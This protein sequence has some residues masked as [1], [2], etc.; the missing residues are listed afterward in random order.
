M[1]II[2]ITSNLGNLLLIFF[3]FTL[4]LLP[5]REILSTNNRLI[6]TL[7]FIILLPLF[8]IG[9]EELKT[10]LQRLRKEKER[11][12]KV[13]LFDFL[14]VFLATLATF[15]LSVNLGFGPVVAAGLTGILAALFVRRYEAAAYCGA[16]VGMSCP[17]GLFLSFGHLILAAAIAGIIFVIT[18]QAFNGIGGKLGTIALA[19]CAIATF[20]IGREFPPGLPPAGETLG[21]L[22][23]YSVL[24]GLITY[25]LN[26]RL[27]HSAVL[28]SAVVGLA[29]GL[30]LPV[31]YPE[32]GQVLG[33]MV[34]CASFA[35]MSNFERIPCEFYM[36]ITGIFCA[37]IFIYTAPY[38]GGAGGKLGA[39]AFGSV[40]AI[41]G[42]RRSFVVGIKR[43]RN[44][45]SQ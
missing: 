31:L 11:I 32:S 38:F 12:L 3:T 8:Y 2:K 17:I 10:G 6:I 16:F 43:I 7:Y 22:Y 24:G 45:P 30:L 13:A 41:D 21:Y 18:K 25:I 44:Q 5:A 39:I 27:G 34:I 1:K 40:I 26:V 37:L 14:V 28:S 15:V 23:L 4:F 20:L 42:L 36:V 35:G 29:A 33:V 19:G 9:I